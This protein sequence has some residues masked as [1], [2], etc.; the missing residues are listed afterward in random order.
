M[1][2]IQAGRATKGQTYVVLHGE[3]SDGGRGLGLVTFDLLVGVFLSSHGWRLH[4]VLL[5][6]HL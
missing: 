1:N 5:L 2:W 4:H 3:A 6:D